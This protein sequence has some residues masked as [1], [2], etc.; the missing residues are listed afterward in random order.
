MEMEAQLHS[1][2]EVGD[3]HYALATLFR[4][5]ASVAFK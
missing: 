1:F 3:Q 5:S 2:L 4:R